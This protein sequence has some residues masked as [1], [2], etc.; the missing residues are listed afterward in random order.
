[1]RRNARDSGVNISGRGIYEVTETYGQ[2]SGEPNTSPWAWNAA[3]QHLAWLA[4]QAAGKHAT[5]PSGPMS[6][7]VFIAQLVLILQFSLP[8]GH[9]A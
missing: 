7:N 9:W 6:C 4:I 2:D 8:V 5:K 3:G 1:M